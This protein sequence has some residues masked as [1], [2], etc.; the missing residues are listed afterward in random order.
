M[1]KWIVELWRDGERVRKMEFTDEMVQHHNGTT[2]ITFPTA[3]MSGGLHIASHDELHV[4]E[5]D[6]G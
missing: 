5:I 1:H 6:D 3:E 4:S 2:V